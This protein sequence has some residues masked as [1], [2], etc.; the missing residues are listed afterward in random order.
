M[1]FLQFQIYLNKGTK[2]LGSFSFLLSTK[3]QGMVKPLFSSEVGGNR[4]FENVNKDIIYQAVL[5]PDMTIIFRSNVTVT[6]LQLL[7]YYCR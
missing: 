1:Q 7:V 2:Q 4:V 5:I 3:D 6:A